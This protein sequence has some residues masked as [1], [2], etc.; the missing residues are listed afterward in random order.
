ME[1]AVRYFHHSATTV[2]RKAASVE[3]AARPALCLRGRKNA[4]CVVNDDGTFRIRKV[5]VR[6]YDQMRPIPHRGSTYEPKE[7]AQKIKAQIIRTDVRREA[8]QGALELIDR[9]LSGEFDQ[10]VEFSESAETPKIEEVTAK[11]AKES[12]PSILAKI[13]EELKIEPVL[14]RRK[15]RKAGLSAPYD[16]EAAI[17]G[18]LK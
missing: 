10:D 16:N 1:A 17:R 15:L 6:E 9:V 12:R 4:Y 2:N 14:A 13:C 8:T 18:A 11:P 3:G 5:E 7:F